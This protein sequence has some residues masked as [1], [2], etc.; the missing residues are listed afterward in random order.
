MR[1][2]WN[3]RSSFSCRRRYAASA[4][5][6]HR[7]RASDSLREL[8]D[9]RRRLRHVLVRDVLRA[10]DGEGRCRAVDEGI[11]DELPRL[12][13]LVLEMGWPPFCAAI[14]RPSFASV[15]FLAIVFDLSPLARF[16]TSSTSSCSFTFGL[17]RP[18]VWSSTP[19]ALRAGN[20]REVSM[21]RCL[22]FVASSSRILY[23]TSLSKAIFSPNPL[24]FL[25]PS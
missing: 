12:V 20:V 5:R 14:R 10:E 11:D 3:V 25:G 15:N 7:R 1:E 6:P 17:D 18:F 22:C 19:Q 21:F 23:S 13:P 8:E 4:S 9:L 24:P 16:F 2:F